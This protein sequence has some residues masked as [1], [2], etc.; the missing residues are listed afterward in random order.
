MLDFFFFSENLL[1]RWMGVL[2]RKLCIVA[3]RMCQT[4]SGSLNVSF[5]FPKPMVGKDV[6]D[7]NALDSSANK[8]IVKN[9]ILCDIFFFKFYLARRLITSRP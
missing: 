5:G 3:L 8:F 7:L 1:V 9:S 4:W 2:F 6:C